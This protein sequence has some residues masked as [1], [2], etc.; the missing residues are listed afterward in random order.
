MVLQLFFLFVFLCVSSIQATE[1]LINTTYPSLLP[2]SIIPEHYNLDLSFPN[3]NNA[4]QDTASKLRF[5]ATL[6]INISVRTSTTCVV[7]HAGKFNYTSVTLDGNP[8]LQHTFYNSHTEMLTLTS[9]TPFIPNNKH[10]IVLSYVGFVND[11]TNSAD[12]G[13]HGVFLS[14]NTVPP[15]VEPSSS[16]LTEPTLL[17]E[18]IDKWRLH[19][20]QRRT[21]TLPNQTNYYTTTLHQSRLRGDP[22]MIGTQFEESDA[23]HMFSTSHGMLY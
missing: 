11:D 1:C 2:S 14:P 23:R 17:S 16:S 22:M 3:P 13:A 18:A 5:Q 8:M 19:Q 12:D 15:P 7:L 6:A 21:R 9:T 4:V 10:L 20:S